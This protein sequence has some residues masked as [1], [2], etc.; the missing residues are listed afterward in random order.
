MDEKKPSRSDRILS[1]VLYIAGAA[2]AVFSVI[3]IFAVAGFGAVSAVIGLFGA[4]SSVG[5]AVL[6]CVCCL[7]TA[8]LMLYCMVLIFKCAISRFG[9]KK[10]P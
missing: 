3:A 1:A 2:L 7:V 5:S 10:R 4:E 8:V 9:G 6:L